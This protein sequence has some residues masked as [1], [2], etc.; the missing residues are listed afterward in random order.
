MPVVP[1]TRP[2][3]LYALLLG[4]VFLGLGGVAG[5][6]SLTL[7]PTGSSLGLPTAE[8]DESS[9]GDYLLPGLTLLLVLG[10]LPL[11]VAAGLW[12]RS[13][14]AHAAAALVSIALLV[15]LGVEVLVIGYVAEP[16]FQLVFA[17][18]GVVILI[19]TLAPSVR[20]YCN[21]ASLDLL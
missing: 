12:R 9:F 17:V 4:L 15:F 5:G 7:D 13:W 3:A 19:L 8:L 14:W 2:L 11:F 1:P 10:L 6:Y 16:P 18:V 21:K 20:V